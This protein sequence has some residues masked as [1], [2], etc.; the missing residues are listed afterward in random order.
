MDIKKTAKTY[1][2]QWTKDYSIFTFMKGNRNVNPFNLKRITESMKVNPLFSPIMVN[3]K[4]EIIDGQHRFLASKELGLPINFII[5]EGYSIKEVH[6]LNTN[7]SNWKRL[8]YLKGY[9]DL[10]LKPYIK[11]NEFMNEFPIFGIKAALHIVT[12]KN[13]NQEKTKSNY[14]ENGNL[15]T[16]D[17][18]YAAELAKNIIDYGNFYD[19]YD[20]PA[21]VVA[22]TSI[23]NHKNYDHRQMMAK[24]SRK[25]QQIT[26]QTNHKL[27]IDQLEEIFNYSRREKK[28]LKY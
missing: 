26:D 7:S 19:G 4:F 27:Y 23:M 3:E 22:C 24:L 9:V 6:I 13:I 1:S 17:Y 10:G 2:L 20:R 25:P 12:Y 8:D 15:K 21:F 11:F 14:F 16:F 28:S 18:N 5:V